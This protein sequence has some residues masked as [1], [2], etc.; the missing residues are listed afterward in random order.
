M[1]LTYTKMRKRFRMGE[2]AALDVPKRD[3]AEQINSLILALAKLVCDQ[4]PDDRPKE[5]ALEKLEEF[6]VWVRIS[7]G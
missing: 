7:L 6:Q 5:I 3:D 2:L 4:L 1:V